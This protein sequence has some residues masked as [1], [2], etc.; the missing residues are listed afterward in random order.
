MASEVSASAAQRAVETQE[1]EHLDS[2]T[3]NFTILRTETST[4]VD[5]DK[6]D[7]MVGDAGMS[8]L[9]RNSGGATAFELEIGVDSPLEIK[10]TTEEGVG[11]V[12]ESEEV[13]IEWSVNRWHALQ[14][15]EPRARVTLRYRDR[16]G[17]HTLEMDLALRFRPG[18]VLLATV[19]SATLDGQ[20]HHQHP[21]TTMEG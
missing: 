20:P 15:I 19:V 21:A 13:H 11:S 2:R 18:K 5:A 4:P 1:R 16:I 8:L 6:L 12:G 9:L 7:P 17:P 3:A 10:L 14:A